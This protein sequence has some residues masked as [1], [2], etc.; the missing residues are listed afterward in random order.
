M[1]ARE[2][3]RLLAD[4]GSFR[5]WSAGGEHAAVLAGEAT[6]E[7]RRCALV[8]SDFSVQAGT[9][10]VAEGEIVASAFERAVDARLPVLAVCASGG[11]RQQEGVRG[12]VQMVKVTEAVRRH[13]EAGLLYAAYLSQPT[14][15]GVYAS[16]GSLANLTF[17]APGALIGF[18]GPRIVEL[19]TGHQQ[20]RGVQVAEN[21]FRHGLLDDV[22][23]AGQLRD[24]LATLLA[25]LEPAPP[26]E[27]A[28]PPEQAPPA[29]RV[30]AW[31]SV[32]LSRDAGRPSTRELLRTALTQATRLHGDRSGEGDDGSCIAA[33]GRFRGIPAVVIGNDRGI[34]VEV[35]RMDV[36]ALR[37]A[38]RAIAIA[39]ELGLPL[40]TLIDTPGAATSAEAEEAGLAPEIARCIER[41]LDFGGASVSVL[42]GQGSGGAALALLPADRVIAAEHAWLS[43]ISPEGASAIV[44]GTVDRA[45][46]MAEAQEIAAP[47]LK[48]AGIV[49]EVVAEPVP[50]RWNELPGRLAAAV[51]IA[52][53]DLLKEA[54]GE[55]LARRR[56]RYRG[57]G[58]GSGG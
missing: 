14:T 46:E 2:W 53:R 24:R 26:P 41:M 28:V 10:G 45:A 33:I 17:A 31:T 44:Y 30:P 18:T 19:M 47:R 6:V 22:F 7:R 57:T 16:W 48:E 8:I 52:L 20:L 36:P 3:V 25:A 15:G 58:G 29:A 5:R 39:G 34:G 56:R 1:A 11:V 37:K 23:P 42:L 13:R 32:R 43:P 49:D 9:L 4:P 27:P 35:A 38:R 54:P 21:L 50:D 40:V 55:R 12:F 51:E